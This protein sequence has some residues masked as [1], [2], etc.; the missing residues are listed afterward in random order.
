MPPFFLLPLGFFSFPYLFYL[1]INENFIKKSYYNCF[2]NGLAFGLGFCLIYLGWV[3]EPF[4]LDSQTKPYFF[5]SY[6]LSIY[7]SLY[8]GLLFFIIRYL[9]KKE[10]IFLIL[11]A[12]IVL[13][14][15]L[16]NNISYGF[17]W[18]SFSLV[19]SN[20]I[21]GTSLIYYVG[22][23]GLSYLTIIIFTLPIIFFF[24][25]YKF[26]KIIL[27]AFSIMIV[28]ISFLILLKNSE[29]AAKEHLLKVTLVQLNFP[30]NQYL[31][32]HDLTM[33]YDSIIEKISL[34]DSD[35]I[36]FGEN[37]YP[38]L[39]DENNINK[40]QTYIKNNNNLIIGST[41]KSQDK[42][43][44]SLFLINN[45]NYKKFDKQILVPFGEF[46]PLRPLFKFM[47]SIAGS[48]D[49]SI[50]NDSR[51]MEI[52]NQL[53]ILPIICY[54]IIYFWKLLN[55]DNLKA[56]IIVNITNDSWFG[57]FSGPYQHFYFAKL[58]AAEFNKPIIRLS[59]N[60]VS[61]II[62]NFGNIFQN[63]KLNN[64]D[65]ITST[66]RINSFSKNYINAHKII[67]II[68]L[69]FLFTG[70]AVARYENR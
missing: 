35:L 67:L 10:L 27:I 19:H 33:R 51:N 22:T 46:I 4:L 69:I 54:E 63:T 47:E 48:F 53:T 6:L 23:Y 49:F 2:I 15:F 55:K 52:N 20:N 50:G 58:R 9:R 11:P 8:F 1:V 13:I 7:C 26:R 68:I 64:S 12:L 39:M 31:N 56:N 38:Y 14:E 43:Y 57:K 30:S 3:K 32:S 18:I 65:V 36:I 61:A 59:N 60:G 25:N 5:F 37:D 16:C 17:P 42:F 24:N 29:G 70:L 28:I 66:I 45:K 44:N 41:S 21:F 34:N 40:I 62:D